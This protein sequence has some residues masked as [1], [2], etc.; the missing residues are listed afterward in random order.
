MRNS[1]AAQWLLLLAKTTALLHDVQCGA[2]WDQSSIFPT[3]AVHSGTKGQFSEFLAVHSG[4]KVQF[5]VP[6]CIFCLFCRF[7]TIFGLLAGAQ[8]D[9]SSIFCP[10]VQFLSF[11]GDFWQFLS[12]V[13]WFLWIFVSFWRFLTTFGDFWKGCVIHMVT[14]CCW[15]NKKG[16]GLAVKQDLCLLCE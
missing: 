3:F 16:R 14:D 4:T 5:S 15:P 10:T 2:Q 1:T 13:W 9:Q 7:L 11:F 6:L 8:W 12:I